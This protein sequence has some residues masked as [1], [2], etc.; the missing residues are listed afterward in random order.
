MMGD[1]YMR[2]SCLMIAVMVTGLHGLTCAARAQSTQP[3]AVSPTTSPALPTTLPSTYAGDDWK[4]FL[5]GA[6]YQALVDAGLITPYMPTTQPSTQPTTQPTTQPVMATIPLTYAGI[7]A[8]MNTAGKGIIDLPPGVVESPFTYVMS[9]S[10]VVVDGHG[11][12]VLRKT[13]LKPSPVAGKDPTNG[14]I[15]KVQ[16][17]GCVWNNIV[18][19]TGQQSV[20]LTTPKTGV[21]AVIIS[22]HNT[23]ENGCLYRNVDTG[24]QLFPGQLNHTVHSAHATSELRGDWIYCGGGIETSAP[25]GNVSLSNVVVENSGHEHCLRASSPSFNNLTAVNC[26]F[27][28]DNGKESLAIRQGHHFK[29]IG[30]SFSSKMPAT[31]QLGDLT[32]AAG[33]GILPGNPVGAQQELLTDVEFDNCT[34]SGPSG[35]YYSIRYCD[36]VKI[37]GG[38]V[39]VVTAGVAPGMESIGLMNSNGLSVSIQGV[40]RIVSGPPTAKPLFRGTVVDMG[41]ELTISSPVSVTLPIGAGQ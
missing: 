25:I 27:H 5:D 2:R 8:A 31:V 20:G 11:L 12:T 6:S 33:A 34:L 9:T 29:F 38:S 19:D 26:S 13:G 18:W 37:V 40:T 15:L 17:N 23:Q 3:A 7:Q 22:A 10:G 35:G 4:S 30:C 39:L 14:A 1:D 36:G 32:T 16:A 21:T 41:G 24:L 28:N